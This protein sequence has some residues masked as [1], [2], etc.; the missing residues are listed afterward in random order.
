MEVENQNGQV[1]EHQHH[2]VPEQTVV[3]QAT[4]DPTTMQVVV[5]PPPQDSHSLN[6]ALVEALHATVPMQPQDGS[7]VGQAPQMLDA[8]AHH[9]GH[10]IQGADGQ[11]HPHQPEQKVDKR[12]GKR[13][14]EARAS[15]SAGMKVKAQR[16]KDS[17]A[18]ISLGDRLTVAQRLENKEITPKDAQA[19]LGC[20]KSYV[21]QMMKPHNLQRLKQKVALGLDPKLTK[22]HLPKFPQ[23]EEKLNYWIHEVA[24]QNPSHS[25]PVSMPVMQ[26]KALEFAVAMGVPDFKASN[27]WFINF[28]KRYGLDRLGF[29]VDESPM[30]RIGIQPPPPQHPEL[31]AIQVQVL[32]QMQEQQSYHQQQAPH[33]EVVQAQQMHV[34]QHELQEQQHMDAQHVQH[35]QGVDGHHVQHEGHHVQHEHVQHVHSEVSHEGHHVQHEGHHVQHVEHDQHHE[36]VHHVVQAG[37]QEQ[38]VMQEGQEAEQQ[39]HQHQHHVGHEGHH[40]GAEHE[41]HHEGHHDGQH[42]DVHHEAHHDDQES[43]MAQEGG[44]EGQQEP[45]TY[46]ADAEVVQADETTHDAPAPPQ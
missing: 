4:Y 37:E 21:S 6:H 42:H 18:R 41:A 45:E 39:H 28:I 35:V 10:V 11:V 17:G 40:D 9:G 44:Y 7:Q 22:A 34:Q 23:M 2:A 38:H 24:K 5:P 26:E 30:K 8:L 20:C 1:V 13:T 16:R 43:Y 29:Q 32:G 19:A 14:P 27:S 25:P 3:V 15:V 46:D 12:Y 36:H 31:V 33:V